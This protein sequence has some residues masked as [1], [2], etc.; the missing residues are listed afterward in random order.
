MKLSCSCLQK[1]I[2]TV[3]DVSEV[4]CWAWIVLQ[5]LFKDLV[6]VITCGCFLELIFYLLFPHFQARG[7]GQ[8]A[9]P[10]SITAR[11][12][13]R[14][15]DSLELGVMSGSLY[16]THTLWSPTSFKKSIQLKKK[17]TK[18]FLFSQLPPDFSSSANSA[19]TLLH[20]A[21]LL[22]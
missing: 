14:T 8:T 15:T 3:A 2:V 13:L 4:L 5:A 7:S 18:K 17:Q 11:Q 1:W 16:F 6:P 12:H 20:S 21:H 10:E 9:L 19:R 22:K